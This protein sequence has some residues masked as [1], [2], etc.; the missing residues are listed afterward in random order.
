MREDRSL[1]AKT[2]VRTKYNLEWIC[3][4]QLMPLLEY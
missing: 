1:H 4:N 2:L 3:K